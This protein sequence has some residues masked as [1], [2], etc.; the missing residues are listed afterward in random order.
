MPGPNFAPSILD[1]E[2]M[3]A[4]VSAQ[5]TPMFTLTDSASWPE[6]SALGRAGRLELQTHQACPPRQIS[7]L[8]CALTDNGLGGSLECP[9]TNSLNLKS[10]GIR[11]SWTFGA[12]DLL[13]RSSTPVT[14]LEYALTKNRLVSPLEFTLAKSLDLKP[15]GMNTYKKHPGGA[16]PFCLLPFAFCPFSFCPQP[17]CSQR[18]PC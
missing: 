16:L 15:R 12:A 2:F 5:A 13:W 4:T 8:E 6:V 10:P 1:C 18:P 17:P 11:A 3:A 9:V 14:P 7:P